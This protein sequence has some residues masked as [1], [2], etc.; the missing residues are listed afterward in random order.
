MTDDVTWTSVMASI[1][2]ILLSLPNERKDNSLTGI[3][4]GGQILTRSVQE[5]FEK[6][7]NVPIFEGYGL[8]ETTSFSCINNYP[9]ENRKI[10]SIGKPL[11]INEM[12]ILNENGQE[13][14]ESIEGEILAT[15]DEP[16]QDVKLIYNG[17]VVG[18]VTSGTMS[19][20]LNQGIGI[21]YINISCNAIGNKINIDVRGKLKEA[22]I[23]KPP[24]YKNGSLN[25]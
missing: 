20:S 11:Q 24:F 22:Q 2:S 7:F 25:S 19:P 3:L 8:T 16:L 17:E 6:R 13:V 18:N 10:G 21:G 5:Q 9:A 15:E 12:S 1:L 14:E 23:V 4:C